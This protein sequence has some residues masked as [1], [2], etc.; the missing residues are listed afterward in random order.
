MA[1]NVIA[2]TGGYHQNW[3]ALFPSGSGGYAQNI[4]PRFTGYALRGDNGTI[5]VYPS[6][7][8]RIDTETLGSNYIDG[9]ITC[10]IAPQS[11][12][13][14]GNFYIQVGDGATGAQLTVDINYATNAVTVYRGT[15]SGTVLVNAESLGT[16]ANRTY[17]AY[18]PIQ[19]A[20][21]ID[22]S[23]GTLFLRVGG[24]TIFNYTGLN[25]KNTAN[26]QWNRL[27]MN[28][29]G[30]ASAAVMAVCDWA[31]WEMDGDA[32]ST[33]NNDYRTTYGA[34]TSDTSVQFTKSTGASN[35]E[36]VN[37]FPFNSDTDYN[38]STTAGHVDK[39]GVSGSW[40]ASG[41]AY[42]V[43]IHRVSRIDD[44]T[45]HTMASRVWSSASTADGAT[46]SESSSYVSYMDRVDNDPATSAAWTV[47]ALNSTNIGYTLVT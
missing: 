33:L 6:G 29:P 47:S 30:A 40:L 45:P 27:I 31:L 44:A 16:A 34:P 1:K 21:S 36:V 37:D 15:S 13:N 9:A 14:L 19:F 20:W 5:N 7:G 42:G 17:L 35:F 8:S 26:T 22:A 24:Q 28:C 41:V 4:A 38:S 10:A 46:T 43:Q 39:F 18:T 2:F 32:G 23:A 11:G 12:T 25:T 3:T